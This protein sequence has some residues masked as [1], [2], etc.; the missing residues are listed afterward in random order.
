MR[1]AASKVFRIEAV[2]LHKPAQPARGSRARPRPRRR[3]TDEWQA[4][5]AVVQWAATWLVCYLCLR[6]VCALHDLRCGERAD[7]DW[8]LYANRFASMLHAILVVALTL[9]IVVVTDGQ[10]FFNLHNFGG[11]STPEH[12]QFLAVAAG[13][14]LFDLCWMAVLGPGGEPAMYAHHLLVLVT[15]WF[16]MVAG[17]Y[18]P[19]LA[20]TTLMSEV[21]TPFLCLKYI[22]K[23][24][25]GEGSLVAIVND[26]IF[27]LGFLFFRL[28]WGAF[29]LRA[30]LL[31]D[32]MHWFVRAGGYMLTG[33]NWVWGA[34]IAHK[35][36]LTACELASPTHK[37]KSSTQANQAQAN[38]LS[39][40]AEQQAPLTRALLGAQK[41]L[42]EPRVSGDQAGHARDL[43][44][45]TRRAATHKA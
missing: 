36:Y 35:I 22:I 7:R 11:L 34:G 2:V 45:R 26:A 39:P 33:I 25:G 38:A 27:G 16:S 19:E 6:G 10:G 5:A 28:F 18:G 37:F 15:C 29:V 4:S 40:Q 23:Q 17:R 32:Q 14:M 12:E 43:S 30:A 21:T 24:H 41:E 20:V 44:P 8:H 42:E 1:A 13:W 31:S 9:P 3:M